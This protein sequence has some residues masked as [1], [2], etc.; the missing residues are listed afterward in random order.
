MSI[1]TEGYNGHVI[2][3]GNMCGN[4]NSESYKLSLLACKLNKIGFVE[5][6]AL[7]GWRI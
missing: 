6:L 4:C 2:P 7:I 1:R 5:D 3:V